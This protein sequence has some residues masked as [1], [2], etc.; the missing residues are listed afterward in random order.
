MDRL[1]LVLT[2]FT[3]PV[4]MGGFVTLMLS[5]GYYGWLAIGTAALTGLILTWPVAYYISRIIKRDDPDWDHTRAEP[6]AI[7][8]PTA[9]EV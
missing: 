4:L 8:D 2:F 1:S 5:A 3:G 6:A 7:P 9:R